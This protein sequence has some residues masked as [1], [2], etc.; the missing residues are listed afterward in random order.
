MAKDKNES[1]QKVCT[2][3][4]VFENE[5]MCIKVIATSI[6]ELISKKSYARAHGDMGAFEVNI[7]DGQPAQAQVTSINYTLVISD[8]KTANTIEFKD[9]SQEDLKG[10]YSTLSKMQPHMSA[11]QPRPQ[12]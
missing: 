2:E 7:D 4:L 3:T 11:Y 1:K 6:S 9:I 10:L 12:Y 8:M 5:R